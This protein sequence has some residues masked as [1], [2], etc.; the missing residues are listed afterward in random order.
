MSFN[1]DPTKQTQEIILSR[2]ISK[3]NDPGLVCNNYIVSLT[4][5]ISIK[6]SFDKHFKSM[7]KK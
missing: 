4:L 7:L 2:E 6:W 3:R 1:P 5:S